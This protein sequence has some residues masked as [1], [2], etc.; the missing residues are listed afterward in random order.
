MISA[1]DKAQ[2]VVVG[3]VLTSIM[4]LF[5]KEILIHKFLHLSVFFFLVENGTIFARPES[6]KQFQTIESITGWSFSQRAEWSH[7]LPRYNSLQ[8]SP[9]AA[10]HRQQVSS[11]HVPIDRIA[12]AQAQI[13]MQE[14]VSL[15][16]F[17]LF[18]HAR[19]N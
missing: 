9:D 7:Q 1:S 19:I 10:V 14:K 17:F 18:G 16:V 15:S 13:Y 11:A 8:R 6:K 3:K 2:E 4:W 5:S 12:M